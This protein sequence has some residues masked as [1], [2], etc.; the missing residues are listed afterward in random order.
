MD[1]HAEI[2]AA[3]SDLMPSLAAGEPVLWDCGSREI[4]VAMNDAMHARLRA[5]AIRVR[6]D[7]G[8]IDLGGNHYMQALNLGK[9]Q[10]KSIVASRPVVH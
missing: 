8:I 2:E 4:A 9:L 10:L 7:S 5:D 3:I 6:H 1:A